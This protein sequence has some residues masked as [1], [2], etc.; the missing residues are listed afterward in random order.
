[1]NNKIPEI[2]RVTDFE[3]GC[4]VQIFGEGFDS[5]SKIYF[6]KPENKFDSNT[7]FP[8]LPQIPPEG[9]RVF[10]ADN[11]LNQVVYIDGRNSIGGGVQLV[12]VEN[13]S[14]LSKPY[15]ANKPK[16][17]NQSL[18]TAEKGDVFTLY[19]D[20]F[21]TRSD[22]KLLLLINKGTGEKFTLNCIRQCSYAYTREKYVAEFLISDAIPCGLYEAYINSGNGGDYGW[23][24]PVSLL[25]KAS[26][27]SAVSYFRGLWNDTAERQRLLS[28][29][30]KTV[31][32]RPSEIP[33]FDMSDTIQR[34]ID[35]LDDGGIVKLSSGVYELARTLELKNGVVLLG[36]GEGLTIIKSSSTKGITQDWSSIEYA[37][38][39]SE[40]SG[41]A[42]D[43]R[44]GH[45]KYNPAALIRLSS[46]SGIQGIGIELGNGANIGILIA[47]ESQEPVR[48]AFVNKCRVDSLYHN[49]FE[50]ERRFGALCEGLLSVAN[51]EDLVIYKSIFKA[52]QPIALLPAHNKFA[53]IINNIIECVPAQ[54]NES[55]FC[56]LYNS[57]VT[58]NE[59]IGGRRSF[60]CQ[61]GF[62]GNFV[63][64]NRSRGVGR[65]SNALEV[66]MSEYGDTVW[67]GKALEIGENYIMLNEEDTSIFPH[68][69]D[70]YNKEYPL[71]A[72]II[73]GRGFGQYRAVKSCINGKLEFF[74]KWRVGP[75]ETTVFTLC[76]ATHNNIWLNN[77]SE[78]SNGCSQFIWNCG[79]ENIIAGHEINTAAGIKLFA[80]YGKD[81]KQLC[82]CSFNKVEHC[83]VRDSG[84]GIA[85]YSASWFGEVDY[86]FFDRT[87]GVFGNVIRNNTFGGSE[88]S[89][90]LKN[91]HCWM[92]MPS[93]S[94]M[95]LCGGYNIVEINRFA[96]YHNGIC[97]LEKCEGNWFAR[98]SFYSTPKRFCGFSKAAIGPDKEM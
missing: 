65:S 25:I 57:I 9:A 49:S 56:G 54:V 61:S 86:N 29:D 68:T 35:S 15:V 28:E 59:F 88:G 16:I 32:I 13:E 36:D 55:Y 8:E 3:A 89:Q 84:E 37:K 94:G 83:Q 2:S 1:M 7:S 78:F 97:L 95:R 19:G 48:G 50:D 43:W 27:N 33:F 11:I 81:N 87:R 75:D 4:A 41:F 79:L 22:N 92:E 93:D 30:V 39:A 5:V 60:M 80:H 70:G 74:E 38:S 58:A 67:F 69:I 24:N 96:G 98:N 45:E 20:C 23:S 66:Y 76:S 82:V 72:C 90:Y 77:N 53:K 10:D 34:A 42:N 46:N 51:T 6:W 26:E 71:F 21:G 91:Q 47:G 73:D 17:W 44:K 14:G 64:Q 12:W 62:D 31:K 52:V 18:K 40:L 63:Y 85:I